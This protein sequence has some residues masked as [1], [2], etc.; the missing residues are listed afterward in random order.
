MALAT[1][2]YRL[3]TPL[4]IVSLWAMPAIA[5]ETTAVE[6]QPISEEV[7]ETA[8]EEMQEKDSEESNDEAN[9]EDATESPNQPITSL[10][11]DE[12]E[13]NPFRLL[14]E[15]PDLEKSRSR[16]VLTHLRLFQR[17]E[18][19]IELNDGQQPFY[20][21]FV[22]QRTGTPQGAVLILH[23]KQQHGHWP[24]VIAPLRDYLP[25]YGWA[26]FTIEL[27]SP[28]ATPLPMRSD[29]IKKDMPEEPTEEQPDS[30]ITEEKEGSKQVEESTDEISEDAAEQAMNEN[31]EDAQEETTE[32]PSELDEENQPI[33]QGEPALPKLEKLPDL[34]ATADE[35]PATTE[36]AAPMT[37]AIEKY[38]QQVYSRLTQ[39][40]GYL[41]SIG[42]FNLAIVGL[43][44]GAFW[45]NKFIPAHFEN[46]DEDFDGKG[47]VLINIDSQHSMMW[48]EHTGEPFYHS[49]V[50]I[51]LPFLE[52]VTKRSPADKRKAKL[53]RGHM[54]NKKRKKYLQILLDNEYSHQ[55]QESQVARRVRGWLKTNAGGT[56]L[57]ISQ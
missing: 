4:L 34:P 47:F 20:G 11:E 43:G 16:G 44:E 32:A 8:T 38:Q 10:T 6:E 41:N 3:I 26:T 31:N 50:T 45:A 30:A 35:Q 12:Y 27:P 37:P 42:Q 2:A 57:P 29:M 17:D 19:I 53:R 1:T 46:F 51:D 21:L 23:D 24:H 7:D 54:K 40:F 9:E 48:Q 49:M 56:E 33:D 39:A 18:E 55:E 5:E 36:Q 28:P 22:S 14:R 13:E 25:D 15:L 52:L